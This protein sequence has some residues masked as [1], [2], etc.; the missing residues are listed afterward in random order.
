[1]ALVM[2]NPIQELTKV[3]LRHFVEAN[4]MA[5]V[6]FVLPWIPSHQRFSREF[7]EVQSCLST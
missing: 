2:A 5:L 4:K 1:M 6:G 7:E 3:T